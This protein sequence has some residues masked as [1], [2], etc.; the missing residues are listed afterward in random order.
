MPGNTSD[1][2]RRTLLKSGIAAAAAAI[3]PEMALAS[4]SDAPIA[5]AVDDASAC[6]TTSSRERLLLD[7]N[8]R[9]QLGNAADLQR[10]FNYGK[11]AREGTFAKSG[12]A[13]AVTYVNFDD[14]A[15]RTIDLPHDWAVELAFQST[16]AVI[17]EHGA[18][19]LGREFPDTSVGWYRRTIALAPTDAGKRISI[20][21][22]GVFRQADV[23]FNGF[24]LGT[25]FS[26]YAPFRFD[27]TDFLAYG[28]KNA[29]AVRVDASAGEGWFYE[30]AGLYRHVWMLKTNAL[31]LE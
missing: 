23:F 5:S 30:G 1:W 3:T 10:D 20:E 14:S 26:G 25:N 16:P 12:R 28:A 29:I 11:L 17:S 2:T 18:K 27:V 21:F 31:H 8:W 13:G 7:F 15:W 22:D 9:F 6:S 24:Y 4:S 19:P